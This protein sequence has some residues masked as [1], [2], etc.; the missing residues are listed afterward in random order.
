MTS[1]RRMGLLIHYSTSNYGNHLVNLAARRILE[2]C[3]Y[4]VDL[5]VLT[6]GRRQQALAAVARLPRKARRLGVRAASSRIVGRVQRRLARSR[7]SELGVGPNPRRRERFDEFSRQHLRPVFIDVANRSELADRYERFAIGSDQIWNYDYRLNPWHFADFIECDRL[8]TLAPSV[9]H[10]EIPHEWVAFYQRWL[11]RFDEVGTRELQWSQMLPPWSERPRFTLLIDPTLAVP[12][13]EW[14]AL[15]NRT[16]E[17]GGNVLL[18]TLGEI[19]SPDTAY[20]QAVARIHGLEM[21]HLS[22]RMQSELWESNAAD[23]LGMLADASCVVTDSYHGAVFAFLF[24]KPLVLIPR[25]GFAGAMNSRIETLTRECHLSDRLIDVIAPADALSH[26]YSDGYG[27]LEQLQ[28]HFWAYLERHGLTRI[29][30]M[31]STLDEGAS[32]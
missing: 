16:S 30:L 26:D 23:F 19:R 4:D 18:Y 1:G 27:A 12:R 21:I 10:D 15:A 31:A 24:D 32:Q 25:H 28:K 11:S 17:G 14:L 5:I 20:A 9:G 3:G 22:D 13:E 8:V 29:S 2:K 6:G 7:T